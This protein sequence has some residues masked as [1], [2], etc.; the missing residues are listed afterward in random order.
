MALIHTKTFW[1]GAATVG[2][3]VFKMLKPEFADS[4]GMGMSW[5]ALLVLGFGFIFGRD[6][7]L[8]TREQ[9]E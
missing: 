2:A 7:L 4:M 3:A 6:A 8:K 5:D 1:L 9:D